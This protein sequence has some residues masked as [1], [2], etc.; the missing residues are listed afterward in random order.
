MRNQLVYYCS[1]L[2]TLE[3]VHSDHKTACRRHKA[4]AE[5]LSRARADGHVLIDLLNPDP[6]AR[7]HWSIDHQ[8][9]KPAN[10]DM[11]TLP[12]NVYGDQP[13]LIKMQRPVGFD[14]APASM[15]YDRE[16]SLLVR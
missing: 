7:H 16:R 2:L 10:Y 11:Q 5:F 9:N 1:V 15:I 3:F 12:K 13:F 14:Y 4:P 8:T 6:I